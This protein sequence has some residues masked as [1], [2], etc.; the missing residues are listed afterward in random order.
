LRFAALRSAALEALM[1]LSLLDCFRLTS[2]LMLR[3]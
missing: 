2:D 1:G 3:K